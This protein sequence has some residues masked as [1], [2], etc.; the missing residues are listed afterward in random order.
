MTDTLADARDRISPH[1]MQA[2]SNMMRC[3]LKCRLAED[4]LDDGGDIWR[5]PLGYVVYNDC[6]TAFNVRHQRRYQYLGSRAEIELAYRAS[7]CHGMCD[8]IQI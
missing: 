1:R 8:Q 5:L 6:M 4:C 2:A 3:G 7:V